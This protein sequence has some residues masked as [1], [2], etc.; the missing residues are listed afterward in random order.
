MVGLL[1]SILEDTSELI[2][3][4][5]VEDILDGLKVVFFFV[6][7]TVVTFGDGCRKF[8]KKF[9]PKS[10]ILKLICCRGLES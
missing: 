1:Q 9:D 6:E 4:T 5:S 3:D 10:V 8:M 7:V 2:V